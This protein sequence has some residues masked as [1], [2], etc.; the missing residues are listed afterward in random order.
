MEVAEVEVVVI[1]DRA[2]VMVIIDDGFATA[3]EDGMA[4]KYR[5]VIATWLDEALPAMPCIRTG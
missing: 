1:E 3:V 2:D 5:G 4:S